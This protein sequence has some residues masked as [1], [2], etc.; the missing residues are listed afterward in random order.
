M[1]SRISSLFYNWIK[2]LHTHPNIY[3][4]MK[5]TWEIIHWH[6]K[7]LFSVPPT[8]SLFIT[9]ICVL[10]L[11]EHGALPKKLVF[12]LFSP[13]YI[14]CSWEWKLWVLAKN[15][16]NPV[17]CITICSVIFSGLYSGKCWIYRN[18]MQR[19]IFNS[20]SICCHSSLKAD[21]QVTQNSVTLLAFLTTM[22]NQ[23]STTFII[24]SPDNIK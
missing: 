4:Y 5:L 8:V 19:F 11:C 22:Y 2:R 13:S 18:H 17:A 15:W 23:E 3:M 24:K 20:A 1:Q 16:I 14:S 21:M 7:N 9:S 10:K 6:R 12:R